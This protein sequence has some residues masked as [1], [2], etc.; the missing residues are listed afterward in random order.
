MQ[1]DLFLRGTR[2]KTVGG[3]KKNDLMVSK[4]GK[5]VSKKMS[6]NGKSLY[7]K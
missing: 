3:L 6:K 5:I 4:R 7:K 2:A 1:W